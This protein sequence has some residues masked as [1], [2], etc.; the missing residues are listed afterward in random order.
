[1]IKKLKSKA[2]ESLVET[3]CAILI[4]A[5]TSAGL[6][7]MLVTAANINASAMETERSFREQLCLVEQAEGPGEAGTVTI[8]I[9]T[10]AGNTHTAVIPV[11]VYRAG[12][13]HTYFK[14]EAGDGE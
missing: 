12:E 9:E 1:M 14:A 5:L 4:F 13:V 3:L 2:G 6:Y 8:T 7:T 11:R 10:G